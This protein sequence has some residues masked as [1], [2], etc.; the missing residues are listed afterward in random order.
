MASDSGY[1]LKVYPAGFEEGDQVWEKEKS[2]RWLKSFNLRNRKNCGYRKDFERRK[3]EMQKSKITAWDVEYSR[4]RVNH[5]QG[6][7][8]LYTGSS[9]LEERL[10]LDVNSG[11]VN[12]QAHKWYLK[13]MWVWTVLG[14]PDTPTFR[15]QV[16]KEESANEMEKEW[17]SSEKEKSEIPGSKWRKCFQHERVIQMEESLDL[18]AWRSLRP[19][20]EQ[21]CWCDRDESLRE[22]DLRKGGRRGSGDRHYGQLS[23]E[24][25]T[26]EEHKWFGSW[27]M[28]TSKVHFLIF[29]LKWKKS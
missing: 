3:C 24:V 20:Q 12:I 27:R 29:S 17:T 7:N 14:A 22:M 16:S 5:W 18:A 21:F 10:R 15:E 6:A 8:R 13:Q 9:S 11:V 26:Q 28:N 2:A 25:L 1:I 4:C 23:Q 19:W